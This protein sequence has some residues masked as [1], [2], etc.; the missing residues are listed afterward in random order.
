MLRTAG[1]I[2][3]ITDTSFQF[4]LDETVETDFRHLQICPWTKSKRDQLIRKRCNGTTLTIEE[5]DELIAV[6]DRA[7]HS[8]FQLFEMTPPFINQYID[9]YLYESGASFLQGD[10]PFTSIMTT[11]VKRKIRNAVSE[12]GNQITLDFQL[13]RNA[14]QTQ[15]NML[16]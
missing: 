14:S 13:Q 6:V 16:H 5:V 8:H 3:L 9:F 12:D 15:C 1:N 4:D 2:V 11:N 7:V 10:L